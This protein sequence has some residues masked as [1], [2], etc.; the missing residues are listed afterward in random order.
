MDETLI[1]ENTSVDGRLSNKGDCV[2]NIDAIVFKPRLKPGDYRK[3]ATY[4][5]KYIY[6]NN[7]HFLLNSPRRQIILN[8]VSNFP[9]K[10]RL[11]LAIRVKM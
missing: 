10:K 6:K 7:V 4:S 3:N 9:C 5:N 1:I 2:G 8:K 11:Q